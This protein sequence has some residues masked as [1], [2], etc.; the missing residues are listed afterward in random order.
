MGPSPVTLV[1]S[2]VDKCGRTP[3]IRRSLRP[4]GARPDRGQL[5]AKVPGSGAHRPGCG[6]ARFAHCGY[7]MPMAKVGAMR[8]LVVNPGSSSVKLA[9]VADGVA[10]G[11]ADVDGS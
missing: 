4:V 5:G 9:V 7:P 10:L 1:G 11:T 2:A 3:R 6:A 8:V